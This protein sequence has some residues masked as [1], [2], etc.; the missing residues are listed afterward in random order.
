MYW[1]KGTTTKLLQPTQIALK[2]TLKYV[3]SIIYNLE[4]FNCHLIQFKSKH[5]HT[6]IRTYA[7]NRYIHTFEIKCFSSFYY[8]HYLYEAIPLQNCAHKP[9]R[10]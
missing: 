8:H 1:N 5:T 2:N 7:F 9:Q 4:R 10:K 6:H 3:Y